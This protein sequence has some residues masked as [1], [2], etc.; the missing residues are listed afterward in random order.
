MKKYFF[1][2]IQYTVKTRNNKQQ[3]ERIRNK[4]SNNLLISIVSQ[5]THNPDWLIN[6]KTIGDI[7]NFM[8]HKNIRQEFQLCIKPYRIA[9]LNF[10]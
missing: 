8:L 5:A 2:P 10:T 3:R 7:R 9:N 6:M 4:D 1:F